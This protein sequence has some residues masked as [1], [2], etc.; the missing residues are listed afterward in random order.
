[1]KLLSAIGL[2]AEAS[3]TTTGYLIAMH[4]LMSHAHDTRCARLM[5]PIPD[6]VNF[7]AYHYVH[8]LNPERNFGL[9]KPSDLIWDKIL[10]VDTISTLQD[11]ERDAKP[12]VH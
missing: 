3:S 7:V 9:T 4:I 12:K 10:R 6:S 8:H 1:M 5:A 2:E 11:A